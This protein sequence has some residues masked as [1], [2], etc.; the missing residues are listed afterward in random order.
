M[1]TIV[2]KE[3]NYS[4]HNSDNYKAVLSFKVGDMLVK[5]SSLFVDYC[6]MIAE[7]IKFKN[8]QLFQFVIIRGLDTIVHVFNYILL[9]T[10]NADVAYFHCQKAFYFYL[11]FVGQISDDEKMFL[12]LSTRDATLYVFK[13]TIFELNIEYRKQSDEP[14][15]DDIIG[16]VNVCLELYKTILL[17]IIFNNNINS[18]TIC[19]LEALFNKLNNFQK[20]QDREFVTEFNNAVEYMFCKISDDESF[21]LCIDNMLKKIKKNPTSFRDILQGFINLQE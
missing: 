16:F 2:N 14:D 1:K 17:K 12:Q 21:L 4:L 10:K 20:M 5:I 19:K 13:K 7:N 15:K 9:Y 6:K 18:E 8:S 11:E 3:V